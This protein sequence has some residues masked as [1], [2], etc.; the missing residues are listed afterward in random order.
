MSRFEDANWDNTEQEALRNGIYTCFYT[1]ACPQ[2]VALNR[3]G[4][5]WGKLEKAVLEKGI[6]TE[7]GKQAR[8]TV[9]NGPIFSE[10]KDRIFK[11]VR[12]PMEYFKIVLWLTDDNQLKATGFKLSQE[13]LVND[14]RF[15]E[16]MRLDAEALDIDKDVVFKQ[17]QCSIKKLSDLTH[18]D[19]KHLEPFDTFVPNNESD[20]MLIVDTESIVL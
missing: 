6:K 1:N 9:L 7:K 11:G 3:A 4:G 16:S 5:L 2:V 20:E 8:M 10:E 12:I 17:C 19:F 14:I 15:D 18:I 13:T